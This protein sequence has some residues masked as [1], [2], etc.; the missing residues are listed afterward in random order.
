[1]DRKNTPTPKPT[2]DEVRQQFEQW[3]AIRKPSTPIPESL[4][5]GAVSL[6]GDDSIYRV[7]RQLRLDYNHLKRRVGSIPPKRLR[8]SETQHTFVEL[9]LNHS[10]AEAECLLEKEDKSG[11]RIKMHLKGRLSMESLEM[12]KVFLGWGR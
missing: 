8:P 12:V 2:I 10:L 11:G 9:G 7:S 4:W 1:M 6:C 3:R 5:E